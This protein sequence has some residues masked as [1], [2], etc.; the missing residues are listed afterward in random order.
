MGERGIMVRPP[1]QPPGQ[2]VIENFYENGAIMPP[3][4]VKPAGNIS[5][6]LTFTNQV[7]EDTIPQPLVVNLGGTLKVNLPPFF[8]GPA[9]PPI[10]SGNPV[11]VTGAT[12]G[13]GYN[14]TIQNQNFSTNFVNVL[15]VG[16]MGYAM[17]LPSAPAAVVSAGGSIA[18]GTYI[19]ALA[20]IDINGNLTTLGTGTSVTTTTGN[21]TVTITTPAVPPSG[22]VN[23]ALY[24]NGIFLKDQFGS[25]N[26]V[27]G[28]FT[29]AGPGLT[30]VDSSGGG[31]CGQSQPNTNLGMAQ[32]VS[33]LGINGTAFN[34]LGG[35]FN[36][37]ISGTF[38][39]NR[40]V[41]LPD[42]NAVLI[43]SSLFAGLGTPANGTFTYCS[44]CTVAN[45]CAGSGTGA[46]AKRL[47][48]VWVCN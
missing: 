27:L 11:T 24:R 28:S 18:V 35:G 25:C 32:G 14:S 17:A 44:D 37:V 31:P 47:N 21:Q 48:G 23:Y 26:P 22:A 20:A 34:L 41:T 29:G 12:V 15:G 7:T 16:K 30:F 40:T 45:P 33:S 13:T 5:V 42:S 39:A 3:F 9:G 10:V 46:L 8:T 19:Y 6:I 4:F 2:I 38:T 43:G 36:S 1:S